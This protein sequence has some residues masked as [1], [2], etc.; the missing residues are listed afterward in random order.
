MTAHSFPKYYFSAAGQ[1]KY[2]SEFHCICS[3]LCMYH[4]FMYTVN[5]CHVAVKKKMGEPQK[6]DEQKLHNIRMY[7][8]ME[9]NTSLESDSGASIC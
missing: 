4:V 7:H 9:G 2:Q 5:E 8:I 1:D 3:M 6:R